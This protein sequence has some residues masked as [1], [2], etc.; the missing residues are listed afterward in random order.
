QL[1]RSIKEEEPFMQQSNS[2]LS[3]RRFLQ[4]I[5]VGAGMATLVACQAP[6]APT[7]TETDAGAEAAAPASEGPANIRFA[8][9]GDWGWLT[10]WLALIDQFNE[11]NEGEIV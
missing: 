6:A 11:E 2:K 9:H 8:A 5:G 4:M 3:R 7:T 10:V 1:N